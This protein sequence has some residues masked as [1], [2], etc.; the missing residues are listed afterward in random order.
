MASKKILAIVSKL[1]L[2]ILN[3]V[4]SK[5]TMVQMQ[6]RYRSMGAIHRPSQQDLERGEHHRAMEK[7]FTRDWNG[8]DV[9]APHDLTG[10]EARKWKA[11]KAPTTDVF[12]SLSLNPLDCYKV[13]LSPCLLPMTMLTLFCRTSPS[14]PNI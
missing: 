2:A 4:Q 6:K 13:L 14:C 3:S 10:A 8:G 1:E 11:K 7:S 9:Y 12:D 5:S